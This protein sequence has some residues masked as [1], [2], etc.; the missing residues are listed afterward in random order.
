MIGARGRDS[1]HDAVLNYTESTRTDERLAL[2]DI[3]GSQAHVLMLTRQGILSDRHARDILAAL[4]QA[5]RDAQTGRLTL[6]PRLE[7]VHMNVERY[8]VESAGKEAGGRLHTARSRNDQ[9]ITDARLYVREELLNLGE[10]LVA[11]CRAFLDLADAH[12]E[13]VLPGY[14]HTQHAQPITLGFWATAHASLL[15]DDARRLSAAYETANRS[16][17]GACALAGTDFPTDRHLTA[18]LLGFASVEEHALAVVSGRDFIAEAL[19]ALAML[20]TNLSRVAAELIYWTTFEFGLMTLH[21]DY[22]LG[23]SIMPQKKN[24]D[25][26]ELARGRAGKVHARLLEVLTLLKGLPLGYHRDLQEDKA[27][28]WEALDITAGSLN[29]LTGVLRT[30][31][32]HPDRMLDLAW[33]N[34]CTATELANYLV[35]ERHLSFREAHGLVGGLVA[36]LAERG[37]TFRATDACADF[38]AT[39]ECPIPVEVLKDILDPVAAIGRNRSLGGTS[40]REVERMAAALRRAL[41]DFAATLRERKQ[42]IE[43][44]RVQTSALVAKVL[45]GASVAALI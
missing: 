23:S 27:P 45:E 13:T 10:R 35:V 41:D 21:D 17:L 5:R 7:D 15:L 34:F 19:F 26:A 1:A 16:P 6:E 20:M 36:W 38:L 12:R 37:L 28:L 4:E 42:A 3:W 22:A 44:A 25:I 8:V 33:S 14:T 30:V 29:V 9:V 31:R 24:P 40:P 2:Y 18:R 43:A 32:V 11:L 39:R